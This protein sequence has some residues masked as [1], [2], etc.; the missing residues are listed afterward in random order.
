[1]NA[2][3]LA[4]LAPYKPG[5]SGNPGGK[6][7]LVRNRITAH[8]LHALSDDFEE[9]GK[10]TI[11]AAREKDPVGYLKVVAA[12]LPKQVEAI[13]PMGDLAD[14]ELV[15]MIGLLRAKLSEMTPEQLEGLKAQVAG[16]SDGA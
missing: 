10:A 2:A 15:A 5:Q 1:M 16:Q 9:H 4:N 11:V 14:H 7:Q 6:P 13:E 3:S 8:F 12:L